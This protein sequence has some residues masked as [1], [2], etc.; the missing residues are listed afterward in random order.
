MRNSETLLF[1]GNMGG[2]EVIV[3]IAILVIPIFCIVKYGLKAVSVILL[4]LG[5]LNLIIAVVGMAVDPDRMIPKLILSIGFIGG[6]IYLRNRATKKNK[7]KED[8]DNW[9]NN[10]DV[11]I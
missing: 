11:M 9:M 10:D 2:I 6:G 8:R 4:I 3:T 7:E 5:I 1:L